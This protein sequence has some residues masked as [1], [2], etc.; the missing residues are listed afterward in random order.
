[1]KENT[2]KAEESCLAGKKQKGLSAQIK[3][4]SVKN[5]ADHTLTEKWKGQK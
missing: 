4:E 3:W 1:M 2:S 5:K